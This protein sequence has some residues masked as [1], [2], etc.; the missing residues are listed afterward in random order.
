MGGLDGPVPVNRNLSP[1]GKVAKAFAYWLHGEQI[2]QGQPPPLQRDVGGV[3]WLGN[4][5]ASVRKVSEWGT[6]RHAEYYNEMVTL[7]RS[8][9]QGHEGAEFFTD[10]LSALTRDP[11]K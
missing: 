3:D 11:S 1:L 2:H 8:Y 9:D 4:D 7:M 10:M 5:F 6:V